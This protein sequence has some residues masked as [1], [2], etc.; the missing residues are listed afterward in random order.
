[1][2]TS[3]IN[4]LA[5]NPWITLGGFIIGALGL[6]LAIVFYFK[7]KKDRIPCYVVSSN[8]LIE[9]IDKALDGLQLLYKGQPQSRISVTK[10]AIWNDG[11]ETIDR[12]DF[13]LA[14]PVRVLCPPVLDILDV[15][16]S[17]VSS[18]ANPVNIGN[19]L[20]LDEHIS[21]SIDFE[22]L[23]YKDYFVIQLVHNGDVAQRFSVD[24]KIKGVAKMTR[25]SSGTI[26]E[27]HALKYYPLLRLFPFMLLIEKL[28][29]NRL[30]MKYVGVS[31]YLIFAG[32]G[33]WALIHGKNEW[34]V[35]TGTVFC[36]FGASIL[37]FGLR[38]I[39]PVNL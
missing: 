26:A 38:R 5:S 20:K 18:E 37:Y 19:P 1:M 34:Y 14:N 27:P 32:A 7:S 10:I 17:Q 30:F 13:V 4:T 35:W 36:I 31:S 33:V 23:D 21:Y 11:R 8:T 24:G 3:T 29:A 12:N 6:V 9:G 28:M 15:R 39:A 16:V 22:Y 2:D 25:V